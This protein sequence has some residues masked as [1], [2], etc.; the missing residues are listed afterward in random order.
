M[1][2]VYLIDAFDTFA[3]RADPDQAA[4]TSGSTLFAYGNM[5]RSDPTL[6]ELTSS[7][8]ILCTKMKV[9]IIIHSGWSLA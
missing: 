9:Y 6:V 5:I 7:F 3:N 4:I 8:F 2:L 1:N